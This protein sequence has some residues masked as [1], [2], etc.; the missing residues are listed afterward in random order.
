MLL[1]LGP[2]ADAVEAQRRRE[3]AQP[4]F[5]VNVSLLAADPRGEMGQVV[6]QG[7]GLQVGGSWALDQERRVRLRADLG[8]L[9]YGHE[10]RR[11]CF[12]APVGCRI[13][14]DL[15]TDN[16]IFFGGIGP[17]VV[18]A[19]GPVRPYLN[20]SAGFAY[21]ATTSSLSGAD[22]WN[23]WG[24]TTNFSDGSFAWRAGGGV[25]VQLSHGRKPVAL[26]I[27][28]EHHDNG[29]VEY[30]TEGDIVDHPD[31][32]ITMFPTRSEARLVT[33][34][35]GVSIGIPQGRDEDDRPARRRRR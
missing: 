2:G 26:D 10:R 20:A 11:L 21:F 34:R 31:G 4:A 19:T 32:S 27:G 3:P 28:L 18:L 5:H 25:R 35:L 30:L 16:N 13:E 15:T 29:I 22:E 9:I 7:F 24:N 17:E 8:F 33:F 6:D 1:A 14:T 12:A 23:N